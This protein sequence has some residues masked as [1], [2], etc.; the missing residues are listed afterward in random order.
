VRLQLSSIE[1]PGEE[2]EQRIIP[3]LKR[4]RDLN[5]SNQL[6]NVDTQHPPDKKQ[7]DYSEHNVG[8]PIAC[9][10]WLPEV[11]HRAIVASIT[12]DLLA[13]HSGYS[14]PLRRPSPALTV[15]RL[16]N[17]YRLV[18]VIAPPHSERTVS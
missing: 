15:A 9:C 6:K 18:S 10:P 2:T 3:L 7:R 4:Q 17:A 1:Y 14:Q 8:D 16:A 13:T 12:F 5:A 11:E